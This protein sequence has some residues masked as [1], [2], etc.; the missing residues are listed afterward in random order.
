MPMFHAEF[1][2]TSGEVVGAE[3]ETSEVEKLIRDVLALP[4]VVPG[5]LEARPTQ[6]D[7][8]DR[9]AKLQ[10]VAVAIGESLQHEG[11]LRFL[12]EHARSVVVNT[13]SVAAVELTDP[14][15]TPSQAGRLRIASPL[16]LPSPVG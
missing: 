4:D 5:I 6:E 1:H 15:A 2:L 13:D 9:D 14:D 8:N 3:L 16:S 12:S 7:L 10:L 11:T